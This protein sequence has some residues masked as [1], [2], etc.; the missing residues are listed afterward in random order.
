MT[1]SAPFARTVVVTGAAGGIG[2]EIVDRF[3]GNGDIVVTVDLLVP[4]PTITSAAAV[5]PEAL[6]ESRRQLRALKFEAA[7]GPAA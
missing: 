4:G 7:T 5:L 2:S 3:L 1:T 6:L